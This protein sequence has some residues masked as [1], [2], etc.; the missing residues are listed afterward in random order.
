MDIAKF[1]YEFLRLPDDTCRNRTT[2]MAIPH[3]MMGLDYDLG[4]HTAIPYGVITF[5]QY[6]RAAKVI[7]P[8]TNIIILTDDGRWAKRS[9]KAYRKE[10][11]IQI[12]SA[13]PN[14]RGPSNFNGANVFA[15][16]ELAQQCHGFVGHLGSAFSHLIFRYMCFH[17]HIGGKSVFG[18]CPDLFDFS[19]LSS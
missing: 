13:P 6:I 15:S 2:G 1:C 18:Q 16:F 4:C 14:H 17:H 10:F 7:S 19:F 8:T 5:E 12:F 3:C 9:S 11:N